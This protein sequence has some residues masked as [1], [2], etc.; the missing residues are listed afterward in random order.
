MGAEA[1]APLN[2]PPKVEGNE[3]SRIKRMVTGLG[4]DTREQRAL[5]TIKVLTTAERQRSY[6]THSWACAGG[7][8]SGYG[9]SR[10]LRTVAL[11]LLEGPGGAT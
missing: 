11:L 4:L 2:G 3:P 10:A 9:R 7:S 1:R 8:L 5:W 6:G